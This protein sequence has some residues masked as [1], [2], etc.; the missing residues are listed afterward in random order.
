MPGGLKDQP[1]ILLSLN[2]HR[3]M[4]VQGASRKVY[5][6]A[7]GLYLTEKHYAIVGSFRQL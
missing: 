5:R 1:Y 6:C 4:M 7:M 3:C 2:G